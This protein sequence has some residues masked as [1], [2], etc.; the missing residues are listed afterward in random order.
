MINERKKMDKM[1]KKK[2]QVFLISDDIFL[3]VKDP[4]N[5]MINLSDQV[6]LLTHHHNERPKN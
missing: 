3:H 1:V 4:K 5:L 6:Y 2:V